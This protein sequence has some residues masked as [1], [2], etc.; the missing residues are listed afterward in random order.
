MKCGLEFCDG[1]ILLS[2][3]VCNHGYSDWSTQVWSDNPS[4]KLRIHKILHHDSI[5]VEAA[6]TT[7]T[8]KDKFN[9]VRIAHLSADAVRS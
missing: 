2:V 5:L 7:G 8:E 1:K 9:F 3:V 4:C 6:S